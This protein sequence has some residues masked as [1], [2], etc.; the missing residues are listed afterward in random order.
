MQTTEQVFRAELKKRGMRVTTNRLVILDCFIL[1]GR[2]LSVQEI[3]QASAGKCNL[4][5]IYR[6]VDSL[7]R[8]GVLR[9]VPR[10]FKNLYELGEALWP[11]HHHV[12]CEYCGATV[13]IDDERIER[14]IDEL[15]QAAGFQPTRH[16]FEL[17]G[18]CEA[19]RSKH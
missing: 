4:T 2:P 9:I 10:G 6:S 1:F 18:L 8:S 16:D 12:S 5:S 3:Y 13:S 7:T 19:C 15:T 11:H 14:L 17:F